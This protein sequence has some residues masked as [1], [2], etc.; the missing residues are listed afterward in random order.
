[1]KKIFVLLI[2]S[3]ILVACCPFFKPPSVCRH[4][5]TNLERQNLHL[6]E[7]CTKAQFELGVAQNNQDKAEIKKWQRLADQTCFL[8]K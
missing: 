8:N 4:N 5:T 2:V 3:Q 7:Q 1:M 6:R